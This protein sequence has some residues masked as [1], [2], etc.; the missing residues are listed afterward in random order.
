MGKPAFKLTSLLCFANVVP[1]APAALTR[2]L[3]LLVYVLE[4]KTDAKSKES[5]LWAGSLVTVFTIYSFVR[6]LS[7][8][9]SYV[10]YGPKCN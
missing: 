3:V 8:T 9:F 6:E 10:A 2:L 5:V 1:T 7:E 4:I